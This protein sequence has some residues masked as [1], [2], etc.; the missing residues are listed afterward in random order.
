MRDALHSSVRDWNQANKTIDGL[1]HSVS[2]FTKALNFSIT[3]YE[4]ITDILTINSTKVTAGQKSIY[5]DSRMAEAV[6]ADTKGNL[7]AE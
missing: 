2:I 5:I 1:R 4:I 6:M 7:F 3:S